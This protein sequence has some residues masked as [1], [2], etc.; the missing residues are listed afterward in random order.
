M[1]KTLLLSLL[2]TFPVTAEP[3]I[4][5]EILDVLTEYE[6]EQYLNKQEAQDIYD[7][8]IASFE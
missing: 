7:R 6:G 4:C 5:T 2:L 3:H 1:I 8:C